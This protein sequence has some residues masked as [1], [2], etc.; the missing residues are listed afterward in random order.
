MMYY[1]IFKEKT[2]ASFKNKISETRFISA[3]T[4]VIS[5]KQS[6]YHHETSVTWQGKTAYDICYTEN[7]SCKTQTI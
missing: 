5:P 3:E 6:L 1:M 2:N 7:T 4:T